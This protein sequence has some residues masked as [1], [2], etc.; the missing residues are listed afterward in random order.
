VNALATAKA[1]NGEM[2]RPIGPALA[3]RFGA[4]IITFGAGRTRRRGHPAER[5]AYQLRR[6]SERISA[7]HGPSF[8]QIVLADVS[9]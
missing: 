5:R 7:R 1:V 4:S 8:W 9:R 2:R 3:T 6:A